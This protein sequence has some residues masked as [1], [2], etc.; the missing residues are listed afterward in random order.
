MVE[1]GVLG[2]VQVRQ[3]GKAV[4]IPGAK[5]RAI[6]TMLGLHD[7][8]VVSADALIELLWGE[9][10]PRTAAKAVQTHISSLRRALGDGVVVTEGTG[11]TWQGPAVD[12]TRYKSAAKAGREAAAA[13]DTRQAVARF[14]EALA[15]WRGIPEL[16]DGQRGTSEKT[17]WIEGHAA[18]VEDRADALLA[19]GRAAEIIGELEGAV[20]DAP[21]RERRWG[22]LMLALYRAGRQG[23]ALRAYQRAR[24]LLAGELGVDP[25]PDLRRLE[26][27]IVAQDAALE[28]PVVQQLTAVTR[29]V[30]FLLTDIEGSTAAW[31]ADADAMAVA[32]A[33]HDELV[34]QVVT[35]RGGRLIKTRGEGDA[36]FSVFERPS[37]A[38]AAAIE[39]QEAIVG[40]PW[41]LRDPMR[42]RVALHTGEV[43]LRDGDYF[44]RAV[45]RAARLRSLAEG[46]QILCSG[47]AAELVIDSLPDDVV[48]ADLGMRELRNLA[49]P[50][51]VFELRLETT[52]ERREPE[53]TDEPVQRPSLPAVLAGPGPF[54]GRGHEL[55]RL[56]TAWQTALAG[57]TNA[58]LIAGEPG[59]GKT[60]LA[61]EWSRQ[62]YEQ[63]AL[64]IYGRCDEDL[65]A[66]YQ[67]FAEALRSL[68][69]CLGSRRASGAARRGGTAPT[70]SRADRC[71]ARPGRADP[72]RSGHRTLRTLRCRRCAVGTR[73][74]R[75]ARR[76]DPRRPA[77][78]GQAHAAAV[79]ASPAFR[80]ARPRADRRHLSQHRPRPLPPPGG[81][82]RRPAPQ[83]RF[84]H[85]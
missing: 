81:D 6:L 63:G 59:V 82:A 8:S 53:Q 75:R 26:A 13:G 67:P 56:F 72:R 1:L 41:A 73:L 12:A 39:L 17:R 70:G 4:T 30:T 69:P 78:G 58:V 50:E 22:Q 28:I 66:P 15:L 11:W 47:A 43:E 44:G 71:P 5:P 32:L 38:A 80:R 49:R 48:L 83:W 21:L 31:E 60:R 62:A 36:T 65:G 40:E 24:A 18:L 85:L 14:E 52:D 29:A 23:E 9:D 61:G 25:G 74:R 20:A 7:G 68:V 27:A 10:P 51:H 57:A 45:N 64:V 46:G 35:S 2:P 19:T 54:V 84:R 34:E 37:A 76:P 79:A 3:D 55:E 77:L 16:P 33:R 42:I